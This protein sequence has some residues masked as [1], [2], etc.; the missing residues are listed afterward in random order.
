MKDGDGTRGSPRGVQGR[1][2]V[3]IWGQSPQKLTTYYENNCQKHHLLVGQSKNNEIEGF[4]GRPPVGGRPGAPGPR[5]LPKSGPVT[6]NLIE[7][8]ML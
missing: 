5:P 7:T 3:G 1:A 6:R 4:G 2:L 8:S